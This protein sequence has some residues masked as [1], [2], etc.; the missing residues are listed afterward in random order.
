VILAVVIQMV[1]VALA[2]GGQQFREVE[3]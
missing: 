2:N 1:P 3:Q